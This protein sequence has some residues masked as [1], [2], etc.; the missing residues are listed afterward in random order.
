MKAKKKLNV[1]GVE[2]VYLDQLGQQYISLTDIARFRN[3]VESDDIIKNWLRSRDTIELLGF[4]EILHNPN[5]NPVEFDGIKNAA[6]SNSFTMTVKRWIHSTGAVGIRSSAGRYGGTYAH[7]DIAFEFAS[8]I[9]VEFKLYMIKEFQRLHELECFKQNSEWNFQRYLTKVNYRIHT[10]AI[11]ANLIPEQLSRAKINF[12]YSDEADLLNVALYG[13]TA[14]QWRDENPNAEGNIRDHSTLDQ[15]I[16]LSNLES[17]NAVLI[18]QGVPA[19]DR[20]IQLNRVAIVQM[21]SLLKNSVHELNTEANR[22][23][24]TRPEYKV[25]S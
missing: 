8:W 2:I 21:T 10:D 1:K 20:L 17:L 23:E 22:V 7:K 9:S 6:G 15:L 14:R 3:P 18:E 25:A 19:S 12:I 4:W 24:E 13:K 11:K 16:V 5:F